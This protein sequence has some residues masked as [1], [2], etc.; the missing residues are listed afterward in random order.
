MPT[1]VVNIRN[2]PCEVY[3]GRGEPLGNPFSSPRD[4]TR[5]ECIAMFRQYAE[6]RPELMKLIR[7]CR[8][9]VIGCYCKP[10][11]CHGDVIAEL[12]DRD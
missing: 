2:E 1:R 7:A 3:V 9:K 4:G 5:E 11:A 12:A 6:A 10:K 8:G